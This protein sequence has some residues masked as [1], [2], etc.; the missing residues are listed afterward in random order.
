MRRNRR[1][2]VRKLKGKYFSFDV[3]YGGPD[4]FTYYFKADSEEE[5]SRATGVGL[6]YIFER[7]REEILD[8]IMRRVH[9]DTVRNGRLIEAEV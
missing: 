9:I 2:K 4:V 7:G 8:A 6:E 5:V 3:N 1:I